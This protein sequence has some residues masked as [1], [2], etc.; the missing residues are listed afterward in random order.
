MRAVSS[1]AMRN[2]EIE[3]S[4]I[5]IRHSRVTSSTTLK[6]RKRR[7]QASWSWMKS[8]DQRIDLGLNQDRCAC[9][10][11][12]APGL[13][14]AH[15]QALLAIEPVDAVDA[16][17]LA[18]SPQQNEQPPIAEPAPLKVASEISCLRAR[19]A[20]FAPSLVLAQNRNDL[21]FHELTW[22]HG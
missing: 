3:V 17:R 18:R 16:R 9:S 6:I 1:R 15:R 2:P 8:S 21:L 4:A 11:G 22:P 19:S 7:P 5:A 13:A 20:L 10:N 14:V 12:F